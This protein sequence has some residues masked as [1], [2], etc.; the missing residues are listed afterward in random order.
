M[1]ALQRLQPL[2]EAPQ[3]GLGV[4]RGPAGRLVG[5]CRCGGRRG[6]HRGR[7]RVAGRQ[8][9][10]AG[11]DGPLGLALP[12]VVQ[13]RAHAGP[14]HG[15]RRQH[16]HP[17]HAA[18]HGRAGA[19]GHQGLV[20]QGRQQ[21]QRRRQRP[22]RQRRQQAQH[23]Q[24]DEQ[25]GRP[26]PRPAELAAQQR[27]RH[28]QGFGAHVALARRRGRQGG[29]NGGARRRL[30]GRWRCGGGWGWRLGHATGRRAGGG[31][32]RPWTAGRGP[33]RLAPR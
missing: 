15:Q 13:G 33:A 9:R 17:R 4:G 18:R 19:V 14:G 11:V 32:P 24:V 2:D 31:G 30:R 29:R 25:R 27:R 10:F 16:Q 23:G 28:G 21:Q 8:Q 20:H 7:G 26:A 22:R 3:L 5:V 6:H 12:V 1:F